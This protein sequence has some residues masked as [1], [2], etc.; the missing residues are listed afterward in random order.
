MSGSVTLEGGSVDLE[1]IVR[2]F[3]SFTG[4]IYSDEWSFAGQKWR[5]K[6]NTRAE[7]EFVSLYIWHLDNNNVANVR[8]S[9]SI[10]NMFN[11]SCHTFSDNKVFAGSGRDLYGSRKFIRRCELLEKGLLVGDTLTIKCS[12]A[13]RELQEHGQDNEKI[14]DTEDNTVQEGFSGVIDLKLIDVDFTM[15]VKGHEFK[16]HKVVLSAQSE[17]FAAMFRHDMKESSSNVV[18][19]DDCDPTV[20]KEFLRFL[21]SK[22]VEKL[23]WTKYG[24]LYRCADKYSVPELKAVCSRAI[25]NELSSGNAVDILLYAET[26]ALTSLRTDALK[27]IAR[28]PKKVAATTGWQK[29]H[30]YPQLLEDVINSMALL[31]T[32]EPNLRRAHN[33]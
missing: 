11:D 26:N 6:L 24:E 31:G 12:M 10:I 30:P 25:R 22:R 19:I 33:L 4:E 15:N 14:Q 7:E 3:S 8:F 21:Y 9:L 13:M 18:T 23:S 20:F 1:W 32:I 16:V 17:V 27:F 29:L 5:L 28:L 2:N